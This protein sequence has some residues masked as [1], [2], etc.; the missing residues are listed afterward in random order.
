MRQIATRSDV[1]DLPRAKPALDLASHKPFQEFRVATL[2]E[3]VKQLE[4]SGQGIDVLAIKGVPHLVCG[5]LLAN[6]LVQT[7]AVKH[8]PG[9][10]LA[11]YQYC[12]GCKVAVRVL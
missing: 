6:I 7:D 12:E 5:K 8:V 3:L 1:T 11:I 4:T 9:D 10:L 2:D